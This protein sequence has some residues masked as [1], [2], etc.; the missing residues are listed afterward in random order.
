MARDSLAKHQTV[1]R[2]HLGGCQ[3]VNLEQFD[4]IGC[5]KVLNVIIGLQV[6]GGVGGSAWRQAASMWA[7]ERS[8]LNE[9]RTRQLA[10]SSD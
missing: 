8:G 2:T 4:H 5:L 10:P 6:G 9:P 1:T 3:G 7:N